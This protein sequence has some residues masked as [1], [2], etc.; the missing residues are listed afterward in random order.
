MNLA[1]L[2]TFVMVARVGNVTRAAAFLNLS[3][4]AATG[5][6]KA[7]ERELGASL[8]MRCPGG[9]RLTQ[10][11][12]ELLPEAQLVTDTVQ[13]MLKRAGDRAA[14]P[15]GTLVVATIV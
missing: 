12:E 10:F 15:S 2:R 4:P 5:H 11:G 1:Q 3:Q 6:I 13:A 7:L 14:R 9:V 8:F